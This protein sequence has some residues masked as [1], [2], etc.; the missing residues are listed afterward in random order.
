MQTQ[1]DW[2]E[3]FILTL[4]GFHVVFLAWICTGRKQYART[5]VNFFLVGGLIFASRWLNTLGSQHYAKLASVDYFD[6]HGTFLGVM[7]AAP[8]LGDLV[9]LTIFLLR[10]SM[11]MMIQV[12]RQ[13]LRR[14]QAAEK[15]GKV[16]RSGNSGKSKKQR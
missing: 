7:W 10:Q 14:E 15:S 3:P 1:I 2:T 12:K 6:P 11:D 5:A 16:G 9:L 8:L 4:V 13:Q